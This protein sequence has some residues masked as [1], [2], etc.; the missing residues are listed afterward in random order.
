MR[1]PGKLNRSCKTKTPLS[2]ATHSSQAARHSDD[3]SEGVTESTLHCLPRPPF[4]RPYP[5][6]LKS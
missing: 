5:E 2:C 6:A 1:S 3:S 4:L